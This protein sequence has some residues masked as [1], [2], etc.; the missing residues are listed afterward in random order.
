MR[1]PWELHEKEYRRM[2]E[3]GIPDWNLREPDALP[4]DEDLTW[5]LDFCRTRKWFPASGDML[6]LGCGTAPIA[7]RF[8]GWGFRAAG[9]DV[10]PTAIR[11][12]AERAPGCRFEVRDATVPDRSLDGT[13]DVIVDGHCLHCVVDR[14]ARAAFLD[15]ARRWL[16]PGGVLLVSTM[17]GPV[18][19]ARFA[20]ELPAQRLEGGILYA[21]YREDD[22]AGLAVFD[23]R[24][25]LPTRIWLPWREI[26]A[27][28]EA[29]GFRRQTFQVLEAPDNGS[30]ASGIQIALARD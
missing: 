10:S 15:N 16:R 27:E 22:V 18:D 23:G 12:A 5:F 17:C 9:F 11:M 25:H 13:R 20:A 28:A 3:K 26:L 7:R 30:C 19:A 14:A 2:A 8:A 24:P 29:A 4:I 1:K 6:E 21:P